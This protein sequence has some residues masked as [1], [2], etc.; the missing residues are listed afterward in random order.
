MTVY[1]SVWKHYDSSNF[2]G[3]ECIKRK[4]RIIFLRLRFHRYLKVNIPDQYTEE[5]VVICQKHVM[6]VEA[7]KYRQITLNIV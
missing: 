7:P 5:S 3:E 6:I 1:M 2:R 4:W